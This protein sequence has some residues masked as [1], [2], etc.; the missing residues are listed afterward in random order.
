MSMFYKLASAVLAL[1][2]ISFLVLGTATS[3]AET[4]TVTG[5]FRNRGRNWVHSRIWRLAIISYRRHQR[6]RRQSYLF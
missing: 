5:S 3:Y 1:A 6:T 2:L 4:V